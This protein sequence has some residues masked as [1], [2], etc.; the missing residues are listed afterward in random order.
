MTDAQ[1]PDHASLTTL[2]RRLRGGRHAIPYF[3]REFEWKPWDIGGSLRPIF[4]GCHIGSSIARMV[5]ARPT[6]TNGHAKAP[7]R[8][9]TWQQELKGFG[10]GPALAQAQTAH[11]VSNA[12]CHGSIAIGAGT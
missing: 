1:E 3:Q 6:G 2:V 11:R 8:P 4:L 12:A 10:F 5:V 9:R 7:G